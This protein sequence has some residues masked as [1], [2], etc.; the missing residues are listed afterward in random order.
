MKTVDLFRTLLPSYGDAGRSSVSTS[1]P[2]R[3][4]SRRRIVLPSSGPRNPSRPVAEPSD[5]TPSPGSAET[6]CSL[7]HCRPRFIHTIIH[8]VKLLLSNHT[9]VRHTVVTIVRT[10][11]CPLGTAIKHP[12]PDGVKLSF[13]IFDFR[14]LWRSALSVRVPGCQKWIMTTKPA[15]AQDAV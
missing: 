15:L 2:W 1:E 13:V 3:R 5:R 6:S 12:M 7:S 10:L 8:R 14:A 4:A 11:W 9:M